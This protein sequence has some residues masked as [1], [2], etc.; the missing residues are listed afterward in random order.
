MSVAGI[1]A[2]SATTAIADPLLGQSRG[3][4]G[5]PGL[6][7]MPTAESRPDGEIGTTIY[8]MDGTLRTT[9]TFQI[10]PRVSAA[11]RYS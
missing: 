11:F 10:V 1:A 8:R 3:A 6:I 9:F 2:V 4:Y 5:M 7:D